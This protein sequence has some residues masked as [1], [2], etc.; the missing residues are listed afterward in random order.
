MQ[1]KYAVSACTNVPTLSHRPTIL[2]VCDSGIGTASTR[3][4]QRRALTKAPSCAR[5][6]VNDELRAREDTEYGR[7]PVLSDGELSRRLT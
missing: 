1:R 7:S 4:H 5:V 6:V 2:S 3:P